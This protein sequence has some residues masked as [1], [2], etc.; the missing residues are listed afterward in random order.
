MEIDSSKN[1]MVTL[2]EQLEQLNKDLENVKP[3]EKKLNELKELINEKNKIFEKANVSIEKT[4]TKVENINEQ[5]T[6]ISNKILQQVQFKI[7]SVQRL[8]EEIMSEISK[9]NAIFTNNK[10]QQ[11]KIMKTI[12]DLED[13][14]KKMDKKMLNFKNKNETLNDSENKDTVKLKEE[15]IEEESKLERQKTELNELQIQVDQFQNKVE[16]EKIKLVDTRNDL[17][18]ILSKCASTSHTLSSIKKELEQLEN[19]I[20]FENVQDWKKQKNEIDELHHKL[21]EFENYLKDNK[22]NLKV[23]DEYKEK[24]SIYMERVA[25]LEEITQK[26]DQLRLESDKLYKDR[27]NQFMEGF[28]IINSKLKEFYQL[29]T[30]GGDAELEFVDSL[31]PFVEGIVFSVRP[32]N[33][34]WKVIG[35][36]SGG[37]KTLS[38]LAFVIFTLF[39]Y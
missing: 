24:V 18:K 7:N 15:L 5:I 33:K 2:K 8:L 16:N 22:V 19:D 31:D 27:L 37:E 6:D 17:D 12:T 1:E 35:N 11:D 29:I 36:L 9:K 4:K 38:S 13:E 20:L 30:L 25:E 39:V 26:Y 34:S 3:D 14:L 32:P 21:V 28:S 10:K 23:I